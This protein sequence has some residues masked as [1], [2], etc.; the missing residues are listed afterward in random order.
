MFT[1]KA[2]NGTTAMMNGHVENNYYNVI[3]TYLLGSHLGNG[4]ELSFSLFS[5]SAELISSLCEGLLAD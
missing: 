3:I 1:P 4:H 5:D 2:L